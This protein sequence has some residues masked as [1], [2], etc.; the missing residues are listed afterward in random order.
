MCRLILTSFRLKWLF[1]S[2]HLS[3]TS[4]ALLRSWRRMPPSESARVTLSRLR[5]VPIAP[6]GSISAISLERQML[7]LCVVSVGDLGVWPEIERSVRS[8]RTMKTYS[9]FLTGSLTRQWM[10]RKP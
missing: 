3:L 9:P 2:L 8:F 10:S 6:T 7:R 5:S 4:V 1:V